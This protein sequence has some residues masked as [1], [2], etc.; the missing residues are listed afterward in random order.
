MC[1]RFLIE[2]DH[3]YADKDLTADMLEEHIFNTLGFDEHEYSPWSIHCKNKK[4]AMNG[5]IC[6]HMETAIWGS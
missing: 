1:G 4:R 5:R 3:Q 2:A 6:L